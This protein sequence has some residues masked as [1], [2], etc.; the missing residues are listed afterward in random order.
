MSMRAAYLNIANRFIS[1]IGITLG[2]G[3]PIGCYDSMIME[4]EGALIA[5]Y[6]IEEQDLSCEIAGVVKVRAVLGDGEYITEVNC[7]AYEF[8]FDDVTPDTY[9]LSI[10]GI[11]DRGIAI[12]DNLA[13]GPL[14]VTINAEQV[15]SLEE[16]IV[17]AQAPEPLFLRWSLGYGSCLSRGIRR[18][19]VKV[20]D[21]GQ[22]K[23]QTTISC[24][25]QGEGEEEYRTVPDP[26][27]IMVDPSYDE[28]IVEPQDWGGE[29]MGDAFITVFDPAYFD[30][31]VPSGA[32]E[33][34]VVC[35]PS[36]CGQLGEC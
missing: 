8:Q 7:D 35:F 5:Q 32:L 20:I 33:M 3:L 10:F 15:I 25:T 34:T 23:L 30:E 9:S 1:T 21:Q 26:D 36:G 27:R 28:I 14:E 4:P 24:F 13:D 6:G 2:L 16:P 22:T 29:G 18:F 31:W 11:D 19:E 17:L 12:F